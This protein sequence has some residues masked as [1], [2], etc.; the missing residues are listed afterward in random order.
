[1][2]GRTVRRIGDFLGRFTNHT[3][4]TKGLELV[5]ARGWNECV[6]HFDDRKTGEGIRNGWKGESRKSL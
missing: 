5:L 1:M 4:G 3:R 2:Y 6:P